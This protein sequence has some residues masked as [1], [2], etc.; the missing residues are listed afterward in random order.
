M[1]LF[2]ERRVFEDIM[3]DESSPWPSDADELHFAS[4]A[5]PG[6]DGEIGSI[7]D[8]RRELARLSRREGGRWSC[9]VN[10]TGAIDLVMGDCW[11]LGMLDDHGAV[12]E[13]RV[14]VASQAMPTDQRTPP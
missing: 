7:R 10:A 5:Q 6:A 9:S 1:A 14:L 3:L 11:E 4:R 2:A 12:I 8:D 13:R